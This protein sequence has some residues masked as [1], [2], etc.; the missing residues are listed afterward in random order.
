MLQLSNLSDA[1]R[2]V[3]RRHL[4]CSLGCVATIASL[5][6]S[7]TS[8]QTGS[9]AAYENSYSP[10]IQ[11]AA[12]SDA[13][14][15]SSLQQLA[16]V[17]DGYRPWWQD[18]L[19][20]PMQ[21]DSNTVLIGV[22]DLLVRTLQNSSQVKVFSDLPLIRQTAITEACAAFD[23]N[24]FMNTRW[25]D[26]SD[27]VGNVLTTG[28]SDRYHNHQWTGSAGLARRNHY[29]GRFEVAQDFGHQNTNSTYFQPNNQGTAKLRLSYIQPLMQG[30]GKVYNNS[31]VV[32]AAIDT[33]IAEDE[34]S[35]QL[36][37]HLLEVT[38]AYWALYLE[39][40]TLVQKRRSL[41][42]AQQVQDSL[43]ARASVDVVGSQLARVDAAV[44]NR[45]SELVRAEMAVRNAQDRVQALV[46][47]PEFAMT[48]NLEMV[49]VDLPRLESTHLAV[50]DVLST[51]MQK[52]PEIDQA[53]KQIK[54]ACVRLN[55]SKN[56]LLPQ[57][58]FIGETYVAG[59]RGHSDIGRAWTDQFS[60][61]EPSYA[62]GLS[63][64]MPIG[65][66]AAK[67]R[68]QRRRLEVRQLQNQFN[69]TAETLLMEAKVAVREVRT[70]E[71]EYQAK[72]AA[73]VAAETRLDSIQQRWSHVPGQNGSIG[74]YLEDLLAAQS[75]L[76]DA[77]SEFTRAL[78]TYN[79]SLMNVK[80]AS[81]TLLE[82]E[83][84]TEGVAETG[85]LPT[86][87]LD[88]PILE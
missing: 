43:R 1:R 39:R 2:P 44:T 21:A 51:A 70:A 85:G 12:D 19:T 68:L 81:G 84:V 55:M 53:I 76:T 46:N 56:E 9:L 13:S 72:F 74:L 65:N 35:R 77:E 5:L 16:P 49:P 4:V 30:R 88:K 79:L 11:V 20:T 10:Q 34:F 86:K 7:V 6:P 50:G 78:T 67:A 28:G 25:D 8:A 59:L 83:Q 58:D 14:E 26:N 63:Y 41:E 32:L 45:R 22:E 18:V 64:Q 62:I 31:L 36:Q 57:F 15:L 48:T 87:I 38:R 80:R 61:G 71:R 82:T 24:A 73:M 29:G 75:Q 52:R 40:A 37:S 60:T 23:W 42:L 27:P 69:A 17:Q 66:R 33:S 3:R 54:A 47:D